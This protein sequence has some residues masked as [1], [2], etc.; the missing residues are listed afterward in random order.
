MEAI[1]DKC[2]EDQI[3]TLRHL[4]KVEKMVQTHQAQLSPLPSKFRHEIAEYNLTGQKG[5]NLV[6]SECRTIGGGWELTWQIAGWAKSA[7]E[8]LL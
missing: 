7:L 5:T 4:R 6:I 3:T 8:E 2:S 1:L